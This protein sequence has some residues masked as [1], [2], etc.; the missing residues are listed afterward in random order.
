MIWLFLLQFTKSIFFEVSN[1][2]SVILEK[3]EVV[4]GIERKCFNVLTTKH[5]KK[6]LEV[7]ITVLF[8]V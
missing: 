4:Y 2:Q 6:D 5:A 8:K 1:E 7:N 3:L